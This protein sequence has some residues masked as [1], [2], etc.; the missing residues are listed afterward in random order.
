MLP[1]VGNADLKARVCANRIGNQAPGAPA[2]QDDAAGENVIAQL[3]W[4]FMQHLPHHLNDLARMPGNYG[5][6]LSGCHRQGPGFAI[7]QAAPLHLYRAMLA[8]TLFEERKKHCS[9][10]GSPIIN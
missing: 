9:A 8:V 4:R 6:E 7:L 10:V 3:G 2:G 1:V 5:P